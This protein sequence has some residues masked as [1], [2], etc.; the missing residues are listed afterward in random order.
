[1]VLVW[2]QQIDAM[3]AVRNCALLLW[4]GGTDVTRLASRSTLVYSSCPHHITKL[5]FA[6]L[7]IRNNQLTVLSHA[8]H[9]QLNH[10]QHVHAL[11]LTII[12][13]ALLQRM[14]V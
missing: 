13:V 10:A 8:K 9:S 5:H 4:Y 11:Q 2:M 12:N 6:H 1:M 14:C 7:C 3:E